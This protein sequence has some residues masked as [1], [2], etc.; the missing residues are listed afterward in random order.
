MSQ[1]RLSKLQKVILA[2]LKAK[3]ET[4]WERWY[5]KHN[6]DRTPPYWHRLRNTYSE[7]E[8][9]SGRGTVLE[10]G[11]KEVTKRQLAKLY[12]VDFR[13]REKDN[14]RKD[15]FLKAK[16]T[17]KKNR[18]GYEVCGP[19]SFDVSF[20]RSL[21]GLINKG[22]IEA[23]RRGRSWYGAEKKQVTHVRLTKKGFNVNF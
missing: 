13:H 21:R 7:P 23:E 18:W 11:V 17:G 12:G 9:P 10:Y 14:S 20:S 3:D 8:D 6:I 5:K 4:D 19:T 2:G 1:E 16:P 22:Y 15:Y